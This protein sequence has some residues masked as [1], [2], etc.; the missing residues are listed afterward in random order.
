MGAPIVIAVP[1]ECNVLKFHEP[2]PKSWDTNEDYVKPI[3]LSGRAMLIRR[4]RSVYTGAL[5]AVSGQGRARS[6]ASAR[7]RRR[8]SS[9]RRA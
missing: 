1:P 7:S 2:R 5:G 4:G 8:A 9:W 3:T 6:Q